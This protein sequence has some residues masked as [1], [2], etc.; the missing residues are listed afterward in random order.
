MNAVTVLGLGSMGTTLAKLFLDKAREVTVWNRNNE[1]ALA[2][3]GDGARVVA[4]AAEA[5]ASSP[6]VVMCVYDYQA[7]RSILEIPGVPEAMAGK[8]LVQLTT[9]SPADARDSGAWAARHGVAYLDGAIQAAPSQMGQAETPVLICGDE[10]AFEQFGSVLADLAG[11]YVFLGSQV[12]A[13]VTMDLA[14]LS[15]VYGAFVGFVQGALIAESQGL[16]IG[17]FGKIVADISPTFGAFF[18][19]EG[20]VI[21]SGDFTITESPLRISVE[22]TQRIADFSEATGLSTE[23]PRL[24]AGLLQ[25]AHA[26]GLGNEELA[27]LIK[28]LRRQGS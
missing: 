26:A 12:E 13:A 11:N 18:A 7:V 24:A 16:D 25:R 22:A 21:Q 6:L 14:T 1:K 2:L 9:G 20:M 19:H 28:V 23:F 4:S 8:T 5:V 27:A 3:V 15:Y 17:R 10:Q